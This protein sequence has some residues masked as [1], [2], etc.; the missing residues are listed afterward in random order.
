MFTLL[1]MRLLTGLIN[2]D[3]SL[4][5]MTRFE[6]FILLNN[7]YLEHAIWHGF[8]LNSICFPSRSGQAL[9]QRYIVTLSFQPY[10]VLSVRRGTQVMKYVASFW[11]GSQ[12]M[13]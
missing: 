2:L 1:I 10:Q 5:L 13:E 8:V 6:S 4:F 3:S 12:A 7:L 11:L 9:T